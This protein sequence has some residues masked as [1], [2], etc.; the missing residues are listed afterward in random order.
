LA[1]PFAAPL[2]LPR[3]LSNLPLRAAQ[4]K[5]AHAKGSILRSSQLAARHNQPQSVVLSIAKNRLWKK[6]VMVNIP[7]VPVLGVDPQKAVVMEV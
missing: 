5:A 4:D 2:S 3:A 6:T 7:E 1:L